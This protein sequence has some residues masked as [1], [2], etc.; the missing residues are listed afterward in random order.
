MLLFWLLV[1]LMLLTAAGFVLP[2]LLGKSRLRNADRNL[3]NVSIAKDRL[4]E[5]DAEFEKGVIDN[6]LYQSQKTE[7]QKALV[8][9]VSESEEPVAADQS[10]KWQLIAALFVIPL[11]AVPLYLKLGN[12]TA[13]DESA[14]KPVT[15]NHGNS[16]MVSMQAALKNLALKLEQDPTNIKGWQMLARSYMSMRQFQAAADTYAQLYQLVGNQTDVL[17]AYA[18]AL[19]MSNGGRISGQPFALIKTA[20]QQSPDNATGLWLAGLGYSENGDFSTAIKHWQK[21]LPL[22]NANQ[23]SQNKVHALIAQAKTKLGQPVAVNP[24]VSKQPPKQLVAS[25][26]SLNVTINLSESL[27]ARASADDVV[28]IYAKAHQGPPMPLAA[29]RKRVADL[30]VTVKL[31]DSMAM[32]PQMKLSSFKKVD[33]GAR[34]SKTGS[35]IGQPGDLQGISK[36][37]ELGSS[38][39]V[40]VIINAIKQ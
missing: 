18:D 7:L 40:N 5:L 11:V 19:S 17:L 20:L 35:A 8:T 9:D 25:P 12:V 1:V 29:V 37:V 23:E 34:I 14:A 31:D 10:S 4:Q 36:M 32:M 28:F 24:P 15:A 6:D 27:K 13:F 38:V 3:Q 2:A 33:V 16:S 22:L 26:V 39:N 30:P 21:L